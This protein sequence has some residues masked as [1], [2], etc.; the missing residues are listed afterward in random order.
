MITNGFMQRRKGEELIRQRFN[1]LVNLLK[2]K[3]KEAEATLRGRL[4]ADTALPKLR[5]ELN[6]LE[7]QYARVD[8]RLRELRGKI[9]QLESS[10]GFQVQEMTQDLD[11][12]ANAIEARLRDQERALVEQLWVDS[13][14]A[15]LKDL[16]QRVPAAQDVLTNGFSQSLKR[17]ALKEKTG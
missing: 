2:D 12:A 10:V 17:L 16:L 11:Q 7:E 1:N 9:Q 3:Q 14:S 13:L 8:S 4:E 5:D 6:A 15:D